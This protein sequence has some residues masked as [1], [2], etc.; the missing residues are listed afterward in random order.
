MLG[1]SIPQHPTVEY[2]LY[3]TCTLGVVGALFII[4]TYITFSDIRNRFGIGLIFWL[5][6][7][8]L[9][10]CI[11][12][13]PWD[14]DNFL[15]KT[16][17]LVI[18]FFQV[19]SF[20]WSAYIGVSVF[21]VIY[22]DKMFDSNDLSSK[23]RWFHGISWAVAFLTAVP[24]FVTGQY[25]KNETT[26]EPWCY[27]PNG[28]I[29]ALIL[30]YTPCALTLIF[31]IGVFIAVRVKLSK[32]NSPDSKMLKNN[33]TLYVASFVVSQAPTIINRVQNYFQ[34][35][36]P[37]LILILIQVTLQPLQSFWNAIIFVVT[38]PDCLEL[39]TH[40]FKRRCWGWW[41]GHRKTAE[42]NRETASLINYDYDYD[43]DDVSPQQSGD[44]GDPV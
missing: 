37:L 40:L 33:I 2:I 5:S 12:F 41:W 43:C 31:S 32:W 1:D 13:F 38:E 15:C 42:Y 29:W 8:N 18:H 3:A 34:P 21:A 6:V 4:I 19:A 23:M 24:P 17:A 36:N 27:T 16:Q 20:F 7:S 25:G 22:L 35:N 11:A 14:V 26:L 28:M 9:F 39:Y 10:D 44:S 30:V